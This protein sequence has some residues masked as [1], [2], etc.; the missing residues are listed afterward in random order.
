[1][2]PPRSST[3]QLERLSSRSFNADAMSLVRQVK[4]TVSVI[5]I[6]QYEH[7]D[8]LDFCCRLD[9]APRGQDHS[10]HA[11]LWT[12]FCVK[13]DAVTQAACRQTELP[14][15]LFRWPARKVIIAHRPAS[16]L[17]IE[18]VAGGKKLTLGTTIEL[19]HRR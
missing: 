11:N 3:V 8:A 13:A 2:A 16:Q 14:R 1:M 15:T 5:P 9:L 12:N 18:R 17:T 10:V 4:S 19:I 6:Q 7:A